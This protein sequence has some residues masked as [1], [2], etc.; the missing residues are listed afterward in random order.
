VQVAQVV[1]NLLRNAIEAMAGDRSNERRVTLRAQAEEGFVRVS[2][3]DTG[4]GLDPQVIPFMQFETT[5]RGGMGLGLSICKSM[6]EANGGTIRHDGGP[7]R[8]ACFSFTVP[9]AGKG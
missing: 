4:P 3:E 9:M 8:G 5:K 1:V 6:I 7:G 2:V